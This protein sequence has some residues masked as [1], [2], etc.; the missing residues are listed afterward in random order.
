MTRLRHAATL[1]AISIAATSS[2]AW[3]QV[4]PSETAPSEAEATSPQPERSPKKLGETNH[5]AVCLQE[6]VDGADVDPKETKPYGCSV[7]YAKR[8]V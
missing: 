4:E 8:G 6:I 2:P 5:V 1:L 3:A 7:K